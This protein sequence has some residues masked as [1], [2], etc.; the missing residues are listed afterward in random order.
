[1]RT[2]KDALRH[3]KQSETFQTL[4]ETVSRRYRRT[5][6]YPPKDEIFKAFELTPLENVKIVILGQDP[7]H[8]KHQANG[9]AFSV[10]KSV[11]IPPSL[12]NIF[13]ELSDDLGVPIPSH[14]D[15]TGWAER[16]VLLLNTTLTVEDSLPASHKS[17]GWEAFT[18]EVIRVLSE[19]EKPI[20]FMLWGNH[21]KSKERLIDASRHKV[22]KASHPSPLGAHHSF[23]GCRHFSKANAFLESN[24]RGAVDFSL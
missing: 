21:A 17:L 9:L 1:M 24:G 6:V 2:W 12:K 23:F 14:G 7:Y 15:L 18:D 22:L 10:R 3:V 16:G 20:V 8:Q 19:H 4:L 11:R 13:K 5:A